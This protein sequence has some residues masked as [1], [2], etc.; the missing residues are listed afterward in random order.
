MRQLP[1]SLL[2]AF[3]TGALVACALSVQAQ[4]LTGALKK[5]KES[6]EITLGYRDSSIP[7]SYLGGDAQPIG[8]SL[9]LCGRVVDA[10]KKQLNLPGL[11]VNMQAVT[12][13]NRIP[14]VV[15][16]T[17]TL[18]CGS[19]VNNAERQ[20]QVAF[21]STTFVVATR[22]IAK[23]AANYK[24]VEDL[25][26]KTVACTTGTNTTKRVRE[27]STARNLNL[28]IIA[29]K[30]HA[31]SMLLMT[32]GRAEAFFEDDILLVGMA[33]SSSDPQAYALSTEGYSVDPYALMFAKDDPDFKKLVDATL[34][35]LYHSGEINKIYDKWF[36]QPIPPKNIALNFPMGA[37]LK[38]AIAHP[39]DSADPAD[40]K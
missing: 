30:D 29:G 12:S 20:A 24:T 27:L 21:S 25:K 5:I 23:K 33:A 22:F 40:Y 10:I 36:V 18:E 13:Q 38:K 17:V 31:E 19:T 14:L 35:G 7:F 39:T 6:G 28:N 26:G 34:A 1:R 37:A 11:K 16:G 8:Y 4:P 9:E 15:N 3:L 32:S 2:P